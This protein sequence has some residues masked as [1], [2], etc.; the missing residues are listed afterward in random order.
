MGRAAGGDH[1]GQ[2]RERLGRQPPLIVLEL[3]G[4]GLFRDQGDDLVVDREPHGDRGLPGARHDAGGDAGEG[5]HGR[6][7]APGKID[8]GLR[9]LRAS[10]L[11]A[12]T[13][14]ADLERSHGGL[15]HDDF[16]LNQSKII[17]VI[18]S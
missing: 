2:G 17:N 14:A 9:Q 18:D 6:A 7:E 15:D 11:L 8:A 16:G 1:P 10:P 12:E 5:A 4:H 13:V 3:G